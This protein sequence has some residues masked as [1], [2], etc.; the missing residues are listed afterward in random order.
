MWCGGKVFIALWSE[1]SCKQSMKSH[2]FTS[3]ISFTG[4]TWPTLIISLSCS[5]LPL[6]SSLSL[7]LSISQTWSFSPLSPNLIPFSH[8]YSTVQCARYFT[9]LVQCLSFKALISFLSFFLSSLFSN[10]FLYSP[11]YSLSPLWCLVFLVFL[12]L[13]VAHRNPLG[14]VRIRAYWLGLRD[15]KVDDEWQRG[16]ANANANL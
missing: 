15:R 3:M 8:F 2:Q 7:S 9:V 5:P 14:S 13:S 4:S 12:L 16:T 1:W 11:L 10:S 6:S